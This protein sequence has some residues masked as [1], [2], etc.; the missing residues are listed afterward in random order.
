MKR[1]L[2]FSMML[3]MLVTLL[4][5]L[6]AGAAYDKELE[7]AISTAKSVF[8]IAKGYDT[9]NY[10]INKQN[11]R[12][13]FNLHW[14]DSKNRLG[15]IGV[16]ID[17][18][19][20][21]TNYYSFK[22]FMGRNRQKLPKI[23]KSNALRIAGDFIRK[24]AP[25]AGNKVIYVDNNEPMNINEG[26]YRFLYQRV[27][28]GVPFPEDNINIQVDGMTGEIQNYYCNWHDDL[29]FP[30]AGD[31]I[32]LQKAQ[33]EFANRLGL[34]LVYKLTFGPGERKPYLVYTTVY[35]DRFIDA[36]TGGLIMGN[37]YF[38]YYRGMEKDMAGGMASY[39]EGEPVSLTPQEQEA[40]KNAAN[41]MDQSK[42]EETARRL[43]QI[44]GSFKLNHISLYND[45]QNREEYIWTMDFGRE[46]NGAGQYTGISVSVDA[47]TGDITQF[48]KFS[49][50]TDKPVRY[51]GEQALKIAE[52]FIKSMQPAKAKGVERT[53]WGEPFVEPV[54][55]SEPPRQYDFSFTRKVQ[56]AFFIGNGFN[57]TVDV[58]SGEVINYSFN[59]YKKELSVGEDVLSAEKA[60]EL[61]F[62]SVGLQLQYISV[63]SPENREKLWPTPIENRKPDIKLVYALKPGKPVNI[64]AYTGKLL[65]YD[66]QPYTGDKIAQYT[67]I[68]GHWAE[69][70]IKVLAEYGISLAGNQLKPEQRIK[71]REFLYLLLKATNPYLSVD[72]NDSKNDDNLYN[73]LIS[74][75]IVKDGERLPDSFVTRQDAVKFVVRALNFDRVAEVKKKIFALPFK[76]AQQIKPELYGYMAVAY[77]LDIIGG[78]GGNCYPTAA[79]TRAQ[80]FS[81][82]YNYL[83]VN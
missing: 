57:V 66:G 45:W 5:P 41:L 3:V 76:D 32:P 61:L 23:S 80:A 18:N 69:N 48:Y 64:D 1:S 30:D 67:D 52:D 68:K 13:V 14:S 9:F 42:A 39:A 77:G 7:Q 17:S 43:L 25:F 58:T 53:T 16:T 38:N 26:S 34:K 72:L 44:D 59:W 35:N 62:N 20:K 83:N 28:N 4:F 22:P 8:N 2:A 12:T 46:A 63:Y 15:E 19:G 73:A 70:Q 60:H 21:I 56:E 24:V 51:T 33:E 81:L 27:E 36:K 49:P 10:N 65:N 31:V 79:L 71:Q 47:K 75:G 74:G 40:V 6:Q 54:S 50:E 55:G 37:N 82:V 11:D 78:N 29:A